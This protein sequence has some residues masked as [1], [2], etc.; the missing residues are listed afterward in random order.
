MSE[1]TPSVLIN[2]AQTT[3]WQCEFTLTAS[4]TTAIWTAGTL[5]SRIASATALAID[6]ATAASTAVTAGAQTLDLRFRVSTAVAAESW[7]IQSVTME[8]LE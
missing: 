7:V 3:Q 8:R 1:L 5:I 6:N 4:S 2:T